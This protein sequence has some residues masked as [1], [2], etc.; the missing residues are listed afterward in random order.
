MKVLFDLVQLENTQFY[1]LLLVQWIRPR[2][3]HPT[4]PGS[5]S[6]RNIFRFT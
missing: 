5:N 6:K 3:P 4:G 1:L 2:L